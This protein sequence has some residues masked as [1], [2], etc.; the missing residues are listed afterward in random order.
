M[1]FRSCWRWRSPPD[2]AP[3]RERDPDEPALAIRTSH[4]VGTSEHMQ[5]LTEADQTTDALL[6][7]WERW[8]SALGAQATAKRLNDSALFATGVPVPPLNCVFTAR[9]AV[10]PE[11]VAELLDMVAGLSLPHNLEI[12]PG[13][14][15]EVPALARSRGM[16]RGASIPLM[17][18]D[19]SHAETTTR[20][21]SP[22]LFV[23]EL[24][25]DESGLHASIASAGFE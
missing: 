16:R 6:L 18:R 24:G 14:R 4:Q 15:P 5:D 22:P 17:R 8:C 21:G 11:E 23:R 9:P 10:A 7:D 13:C 1:G 2:Q 20:A 3:A 12:R 25:P 19:A